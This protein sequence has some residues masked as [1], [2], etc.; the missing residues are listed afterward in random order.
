VSVG[1]SNKTHDFACFFRRRLSA[2]DVVVGAV[3]ALLKK[4]FG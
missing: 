2:V 1:S 4:T 3:V